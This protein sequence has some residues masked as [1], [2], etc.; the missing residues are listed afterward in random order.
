MIYEVNEN[1]YFGQTN[2]FFCFEAVI[3][4]KLNKLKD[5][6]IF[7]NKGGYNISKQWYNIA[8]ANRRFALQALAEYRGKPVRTET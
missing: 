1:K 4:E 8:A 6:R 2:K 7:H 5:L 3:D